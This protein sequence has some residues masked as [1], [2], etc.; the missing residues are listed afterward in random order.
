MF[1]QNDEILRKL[2]MGRLGPDFYANFLT[3]LIMPPIILIGFNI[4]YN[5]DPNFNM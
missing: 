5:E 4:I 3:Y 1:F 2:V